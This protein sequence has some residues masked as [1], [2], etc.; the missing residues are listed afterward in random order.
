MAGDRGA[1][2]APVFLSY[3]SVDREA[4]LRIADALEAAGI[5]A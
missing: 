1:M 3:A 2:S 4:A 5:P